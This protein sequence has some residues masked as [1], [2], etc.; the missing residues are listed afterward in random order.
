MD[1]KIITTLVLVFAITAMPGMSSAKEAVPDKALFTGGISLMWVG[2]DKYS[3]DLSISSGKAVCTIIVNATSVKVDNVN[4]SV[5]LQQYKSGS[6]TTIESWDQGTSLI[7]GKA[8]FNE[9]FNIS[10][11]FTYR[12][13]GTIKT[14]KNGKLLDTCAITS[15]EEAY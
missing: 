6:W 12:F 10:K 13:T 5:K 1:K 8:K 7:N 2:M 4:F 11:G 14:Y 3:S 15:T 9:S